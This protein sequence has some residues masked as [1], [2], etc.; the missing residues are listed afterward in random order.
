VFGLKD[1]SDYAAYNDKFDMLGY[2]TSNTLYNVGMPVFFI[3]FY[4]VLLTTYLVVMR[5][6]WTIS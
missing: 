6:P 2:S 5:M 1:D 3:L 4:L